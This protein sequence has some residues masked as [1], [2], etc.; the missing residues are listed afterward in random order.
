MQ[1]VLF[2]ACLRR[3]NQL[4][5]P[6]N[7][8]PVPFS[9]SRFPRSRFP[10]SFSAFHSLSKTSAIAMRVVNPYFLEV[11]LTPIIGGADIDELAEYTSLDSTDETAVRHVIRELIVP[12]WAT[13][14]PQIR[15]RVQLAY[16]YYLSRPDTD[17]GKVFRSIMPPFRS[18]PVPRKFF[19][20]IWEECCPGEDYQMSSFGEIV[21][22]IDINEPTELWGT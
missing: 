8:G 16:R 5:Y 10:R 1:L 6:V 9:A 13:L 17:F 4:A 20:W 11:P 14:G 21:V 12:F 19:L 3:L 7:I 2:L 22:R 15:D 18:P